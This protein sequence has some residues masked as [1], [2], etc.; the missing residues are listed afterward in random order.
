M[1]ILINISFQTG[2]AVFTAFF[3][4]LRLLEKNLPPGTI[5][6]P[7]LGKYASLLNGHTYELQMCELLF[8]WKSGKSIKGY[9]YS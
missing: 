6:M 9:N 1:A 2:L 3:V 4:L 8:S 5:Y 7:L